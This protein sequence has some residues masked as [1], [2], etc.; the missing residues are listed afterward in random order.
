[1]NHIADR[2]WYRIRPAHLILFPLSLLFGLVVAVRRALFA[3][4]WLKSQRLPVPVIVVGNITVG[5]T[6]K[7][8]LVLWLAELLAG[9]GYRPGI[10]TR[11]YGGSEDVQEVPDDADPARAGDEAVLL[12]QRSRCPVWA[13]R[14]RVAAGRA[15]LRHHPDVNVIISDDG[16]QHYRLAR[17][18]EIVV[19]DGE[20]RFGNG[21]LLPAG[22]LREPR[23]RLRSVDAVAVNGGSLDGLPHAFGMRLTGE[24]LVNLKNRVLVRLPRDFAGVTLHAIAG[25]GNPQR[26]FGTLVDLGLQF[27]A[28]AFPD[29]YAFRPEDLELPGA[30]AV[31]MTEKDAV[32]CAAFAREHFWFLPVEARVDTALGDLILDRLKTR[33]GPQAA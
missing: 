24:V 11:G 6:G 7:T 3:G 27:A 2:F 23:R 8:P 12:A 17:D 22:P 5:G 21:M 30:E 15:L 18:I 25:I 31:L 26:F 14:D 33:H 29:H 4:G 32:K 16:L 9:A 28:H 13:G 1:M 19:I 10:V 20:R